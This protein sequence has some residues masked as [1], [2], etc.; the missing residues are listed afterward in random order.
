MHEALG[1][2]ERAGRIAGFLSAPWFAAGSWLR[3]ARVLHPRGQTYEA[4]VV[5]S[6]GRGQA[7][8][9]RL[10]GQ[11]LV[12][13][14]G[15]MWKRPVPW[16]EVLGVAVRFRGAHAA[17][18]VPET[19]DQDLLFATIRRPWTL[20]TAPWLTDASDYLSDDYFAVS[21]FDTPELGRVYFRLRP[22]RASKVQ[23]TRPE[24]L[25]EAVWRDE[26]RF[27]LSARPAWHLGWIEAATI[28]L[29]TRALIDDDALRF[30]PFRTGRQIVP[31]G[32]VHALRPS[33]Y[34]ASQRARP[35]R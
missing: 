26:A 12:R 34:A 27:V 24:R 3:Q 7:L 11:A 22:A 23:G 30:S 15:A 31:R 17:S 10:A 6:A 14:S 18:P 21:P 33:V 28:E 13:C 9:E 4:R 1:L 35:G 5:P 16:F 19:D 20:A 2:G 25:E 29:V 8:G 32:F